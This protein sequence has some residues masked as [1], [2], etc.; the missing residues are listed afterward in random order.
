MPRIKAAMSSSLLTL[1]RTNSAFP[2]PCW[3]C[4][5]RA[6]PP[7][8]SRS[9]PTTSAPWRANSSAAALPMP[10]AAPLT[11]T[12]RSANFISFDMCCSCFWRSSRST[13]GRGARRQ[14]GQPS[15]PVDRRVVVG[16][17]EGRCVQRQGQEHLHA[18]TDVEDD[19][20]QAHHFG[21]YVAEAVDAEQLAVVGAEDQLEQSAVAGDDPAWGDGQVAAADRVGDAGTLDLLFG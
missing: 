21:G 11:I 14:L 7:A 9:A 2:P 1:V 8:S 15:Q 4:A 19:V 13:R 17:A 5:A 18:A 16:V 3:I 12:M 10:D 6:C 20:A